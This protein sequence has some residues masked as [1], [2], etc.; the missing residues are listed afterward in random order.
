VDGKKG[1]EGPHLEMWPR[2]ASNLKTALVGKTTIY[3]AQVDLFKS[4]DWNDSLFSVDMAVYKCI[5]Y[6]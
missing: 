4:F 6:I 1:G 2:V 3:L 5:M